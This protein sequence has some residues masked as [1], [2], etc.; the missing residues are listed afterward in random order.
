MMIFLVAL[1]ALALIP[2]L[3]LFVEVLAAL[4][5]RSEYETGNGTTAGPVAV[6]VPA[7]NEGRGIIP[8]LEDVIPQLR[9]RDRLIVVADNCTDDTA[10]V[11]GAHGAEVLPRDEPDRRG[12]GYAMAWAIAHLKQNPPEFVLFVD[13]DCRL[14]PDF[15][16]KTLGYSVE[17][18]GPVQ[19]LYLMTGVE[20]VQ[21]DQRVA[22][23]AWRL[24]NWVRPLG[25]RC[26]GRP[27]Q[28]MGT[29]MIFPW[30]VI[31][32]APLASGNIV[33]DLKLGLDLALSGTPAR[34]L[35]A[36]RVT[37]EFAAT[38]RGVESQRRRWIEGH[39]AM[40]GSYVPRLLAASIARRNPD[41]LVLAL[42]LVVPPLSLLV[43]IALGVAALG[44]T[45]TLLIGALLPAVLALLNLS[46][47]ASAL[48]LAWF[49][50]GRDILPASR[51]PSVAGQVLH[52]FRL[53]RHLVRRGSSGWVR[54]DRH[55]PE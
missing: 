20:G 6:V 5:A 33:E 41:A 3:V 25:L 9:R 39:L 32:S 17:T 40:I 51:I 50:F 16:A 38:E 37:S 43:A 46:L 4:G 42:D 31:N 1:I 13:A 48:A 14:Q 49:R 44:G 10:A 22:E 47:L 27:V 36:V 53:L 24:K 52:R 12:K 26:L 29:G 21:V 35:S 45:Y 11:S 30:E 7:H 55:K 28:L 2:T 34:F 19:A 8:T 23:F 15:L 54:T 18:G